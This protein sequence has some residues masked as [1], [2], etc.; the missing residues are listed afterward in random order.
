MW[1]VPA[2]HLGVHAHSSL[3]TSS[4]V[5][6]ALCVAYRLLLLQNEDDMSC[7]AMAPSSKPPKEAQE[8]GLTHDTGSAAGHRVTH[9]MKQ[10]LGRLT[11]AC[12]TMLGQ[13][14]CEPAAPGAATWA[15]T[16]SCRG[17]LSGRALASLGA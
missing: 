7:G 17:H 9:N 6:P 2:T 8:A 14:P 12:S 1:S 5:G 16:N 11:A 15:G 3:Q 4:G 10:L 13:P